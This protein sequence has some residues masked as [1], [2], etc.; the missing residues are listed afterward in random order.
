MG[1]VLKS[2]E[3]AAEEV[4]G[5]TLTTGRF[6]L[7]VSGLERGLVYEGDDGELIVRR[8]LPAQRLPQYLVHGA[9]EHLRAVVR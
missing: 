2:Q 7:L 1:N 6:V 9:V 5:A 8:Q 3:R 4:G